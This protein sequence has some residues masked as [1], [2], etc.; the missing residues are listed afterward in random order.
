MTGGSAQR[1]PSARLVRPDYPAVARRRQALPDGA[2]RARVALVGANGHGIHHRRA[3]AQLQEAGA[4][5]L[6]ALCDVRSIEHDD[7]APVPPTA[8][9]FTEYR[10]LLAATEPEVVA[11]ATPPH[12]HLEIATAAARAGAD[13]LLEKPPFVSW[14]EQEQFAGV[15]AET[16]RVCQVGFQAL[17]SAAMAEL[18][19]AIRAGRFGAVTGIGAC[20]RWQRPDRYY[21]RAPWAGRRELDGRPVLDGAL[22]NPFAHAVMQSFAI[23]EAAGPVSIA[24][25]TLE[26][27][28]ARPIEVD[29]TGVLA[30]RLESG[31][32]VVVAVT[33][34]SDEYRDPEI[35]I[36][37]ERGRAVL[38]YTAD[39]LQLPGD[40][41]LRPVPGRIGLLDN[42][43]AHRA[44]PAAV[45]LLAGLERTAPF[46][47]VIEAIMAD[48]PPVP[49]G[50]RWKA[51]YGTGPGRIVTV[52]GIG[53]VMRDAAEQL[54]L[55][56]EL[57]V[58]WAIAKS[59]SKGMQQTRP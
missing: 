18:S 24:D 56:S 19:D 11:I 9:V 20:G 39:R 25:L 26:R 42:L 46:T 12:T 43:L 6:V 45:P 2:R 10:E 35:V 31:L 37:G 21:A 32:R 58:P 47:E 17:G 40:A 36:H 1:R 27:Y 13:V 52:P 54:R 22:A 34:C 41:E 5:E 51:E 38:D 29:D 3:I 49:I 28:R 57:G 14:T 8:R 7:A 44:A 50:D 4:A 23:A 59:L 33:L 30:A 55:P 48:G 15:L 16:G 53:A